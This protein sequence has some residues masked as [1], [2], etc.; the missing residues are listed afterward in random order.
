[1]KTADQIAAL[2]AALTHIHDQGI[3][4]WDL[5]AYAIAHAA[6]KEAS[7]EDPEDWDNQAVTGLEYLDEQL[8]A[9]LD[10]P[11]MGPNLLREAIDLYKQT[12]A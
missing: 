8:E 1:M 5:L 2:Q 6:N 4:A 3:E 12:H 10:D 11:A 9:E 7:E